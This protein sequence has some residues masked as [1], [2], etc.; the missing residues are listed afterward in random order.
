LPPATAHASQT[1]TLIIIQRKMNVWTKKPKLSSAYQGDDEFDE[2]EK[3]G[4][5][6]EF[7]VQFGFPKAAANDNEDNKDSN[8]DNNSFPAEVGFNGK[9]QVWDEEAEVDDGEMLEKMEFS[10]SEKMEFSESD[11]DQLWW[12]A[13]NFRACVLILLV[14]IIIIIVTA[15]SA[16]NDKGNDDSKTVDRSRA[17][18]QFLIDNKIS[19]ETD[20]RTPGT[21]QSRAALFIANGDSYKIGL[22]QDTTRRFVE[23]YVLALLYYH[24]KGHNWTYQLNFLVPLDH[25]TWY[26]RFYTKS[27]NTLR[28]GVLCNEPNGHVTKLILRKKI[29][30]EVAWNPIF[31]L[32]QD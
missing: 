4:K 1:G 18:M 29:L 15:L 9:F 26:S 24:F 20:L 30:V 21:P 27:G 6:E 7:E 19:K 23:R 2:K 22:T 28:E 11:K 12:K 31:F 8:D 32:F 13:W 5:F 14:I 16:G 17:V 10:E 3:N 25:C